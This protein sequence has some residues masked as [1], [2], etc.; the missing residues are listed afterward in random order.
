M[1]FGGQIRDA[2]FEGTVEG[3]K[4]TGDSPLKAAAREAN[5]KQRQRQRKETQR[6]RPSRTSRNP[7]SR[8]QQSPSKITLS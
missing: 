1:D 3:D 7:K 4:I 6:P 8:V 5:G 2:E